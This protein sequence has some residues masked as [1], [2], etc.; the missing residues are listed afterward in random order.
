MMP[1]HDITAFP[2]L[3]TNISMILFKNLIP[4]IDT[5]ESR[6]LI[7][8]PVCLTRPVL[9][10]VSPPPC[11]QPC[12]PILCWEKIALRPQFARAHLAAMLGTPIRRNRDLCSPKSLMKSP[13]S[14]SVIGCAG[15]P[16]TSDRQGWS[17]AI[18]S[19]FTRLI[20][21][22]ASNV[23][24]LHL[25]PYQHAAICHVVYSSVLMAPARPNMGKHHDIMPPPPHPSKH[26]DRLWNKQHPQY[27]SIKSECVCEY[28]EENTHTH[29]D[30]NVSTYGSQ[31]LAYS[32]LPTIAG[33]V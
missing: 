24:V 31:P 30:V 29:T 1:F 9:L 28:V 10:S 18:S 6:G 26:S 17:A 23:C 5:R 13:S 14:S 27:H 7:G 2:R 33:R 19:Y 12:N 16:H 11:Y 3:D 4:V 22:L 21:P 15:Q 20:S 25:Q 8:L 32:C